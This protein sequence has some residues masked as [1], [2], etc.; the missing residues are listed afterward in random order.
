MDNETSQI[1][2]EQIKNLPPS[3]V[4]FLA[5]SN[6]QGIL[7]N[8]VISSSLAPEVADVLENEVVLV[9]AGLVHPEAFHTELQ[10]QSG[11]DEISLSNVINEVEE[12]IFDPVRPEL[13][14]F[15]EEQV[16]LENSNEQNTTEEPKLAEEP[17][18]IPVQK[19][20]MPPA[21]VRVWEKVPEVVPHNLPTEEGLS[22]PFE[23]KMK[24]VFTPKSA[25]VSDFSLG[26]TMEPRISDSMSHARHDPYRE[27]IE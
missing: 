5:S 23:E 20:S 16:A 1:L 4:D 3:V 25:P 17:T 22:S 15:Y 8:I 11:L 2:K 14:K 7:T 9:L 27:P 12:K 26:T 24:K 6:W 13:V 19:E 18:E 21:T 10:Q